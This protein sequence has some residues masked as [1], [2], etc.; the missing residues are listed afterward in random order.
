[1]KRISLA[2]TIVLFLCT[3]ASAQ[4]YYPNVYYPSSGITKNI[5][6]HDSSSYSIVDRLN[7]YE[8][9]NSVLNLSKDIDD[10]SRERIYFEVHAGP[11]LWHSTTGPKEHRDSVGIF[12][13]FKYNLHN[14]KR[15]RN[16]YVLTR[17]AKLRNILSVTEFPFKDSM[18]IRAKKIE[19]E[20]TEYEQHFWWK[21]LSVGFGYYFDGIYGTEHQPIVGFIG[22]DFGD[23][24]TLQTGL[25]NHSQLYI[26]ASVDISTPAYIFA[27]NFF[28]I[29]LR[30][31]NLGSGSSTYYGDSYQ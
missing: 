1:M 27:Q 19:D 24:L 28:N 12:M 23:H 26:G 25:S 14:P 15:V 31:T 16:N 22:Y 10:R 17:I 7:E 13:S 6:L 18:L 11:G 5:N 9:L 2:L 4:R 29:V 20:I 3:C 8:I 30:K 21:R